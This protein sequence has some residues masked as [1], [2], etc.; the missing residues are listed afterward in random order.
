MLR[1]DNSSMKLN[2]ITGLVTSYHIKS[3]L[4]WLG[5]Y[6]QSSEIVSPHSGLVAVVIFLQKYFQRLW[7]FQFVHVRVA[8]RGCLIR[9]GGGVA[10]G[11]PVAD[12]GA[13]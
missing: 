7:Q 4:V 8:R 5:G 12:D 3:T 10:A 1:I 6:T 2:V 9:G 11:Q 13:R